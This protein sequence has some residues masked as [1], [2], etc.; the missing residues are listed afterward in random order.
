MQ[1]PAID[2]LKPPIQLRLPLQSRTAKMFIVERRGFGLSKRFY[3]W[4]FVLLLVFGF[5]PLLTLHIHYD[6]LD[7]K[8]N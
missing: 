8:K 4:A 3:F 1:V 7:A 6:P 2:A 5:L